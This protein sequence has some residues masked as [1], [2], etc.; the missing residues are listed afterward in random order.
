MRADVSRSALSRQNLFTLWNHIRFSSIVKRAGPIGKLCM[1][2]EE[3][4]TFLGPEYDPK[5]VT[6]LHNK[7]QN[8]FL[9]THIH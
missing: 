5:F 8:I 6:E 2:E 7:R 3:E 9:H 4:N 1:D